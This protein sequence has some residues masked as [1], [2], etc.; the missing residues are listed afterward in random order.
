[1]RDELWMCALLK[2]KCRGR[3]MR[4]T[5]DLFDIGL[6]VRFNRNKRNTSG[7]WRLCNNVM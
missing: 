3:R 4:N 2:A 5:C 7:C 6:E 1:M